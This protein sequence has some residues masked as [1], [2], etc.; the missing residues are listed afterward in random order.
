LGTNLVQP[1]TYEQNWIDELTV[2]VY[3]DAVTPLTP[4]TVTP[5]SLTVIQAPSIHH[6]DVT[7]TDDILTLAQVYFPEYAIANQL[8][9]STDKEE[10]T[11]TI[12]VQAWNTLTYS[13][14]TAGAQ[15]VLRLTAWD[16]DKAKNIMFSLV[17]EKT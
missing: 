14:L 3:T 1:P 15:R 16:E 6:I 8:A 9:T 7:Y 17:L 11:L 10:E 5:Q 13:G 12:D 2:T 4:V